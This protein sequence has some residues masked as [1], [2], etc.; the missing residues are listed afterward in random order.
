VVTW[1]RG[2]MNA[3][4][5]GRMVDYLVDVLDRVPRYT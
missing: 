4:K 3:G 1:V 2:E 5:A